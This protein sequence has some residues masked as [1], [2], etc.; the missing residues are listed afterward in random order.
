[1]LVLRAKEMH[2]A[3][4]RYDAL[5]AFN[6]WSKVTINNINDILSINRLV[7]SQRHNEP[8]FS[9]MG[10]NVSADNV[11]SIPS[12][13]SIEHKYISWPRAAIL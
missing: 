9:L 6:L 13:G 1:M 11:G 3:L 7:S 8:F 12:H 10:T 5:N 2:M 4:K